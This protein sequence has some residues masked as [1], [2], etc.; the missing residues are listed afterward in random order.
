MPADPELDLGAVFDEHTAAEFE[1]H[2]ADATM[3]TMTDRP[4]LTHVPVATGVFGAR[5]HVEL[6]NDGPVTVLLEA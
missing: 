1:L 3:A 5:M 2:D 6:S 4:F